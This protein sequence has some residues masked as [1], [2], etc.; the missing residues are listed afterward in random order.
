MEGCDV[1]PCSP[2]MVYDREMTP[3]KCIP[4]PFCNTPACTV[5]GRQYRLYEQI[6]DPAVCRQDCEVWYGFF[7]EFLWD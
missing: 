5:N 4:E 6:K 2:G 1:K 7:I 3:M